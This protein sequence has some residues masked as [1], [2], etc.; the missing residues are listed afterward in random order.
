MR[1]PFRL[2]L[3]AALAVTAAAAQAD[4]LIIAKHHSDAIEFMGQKQPATD[5]NV[6]TWIGKGKVARL[7]PDL[8]VIV[9]ADI[10][11]MYL[12]RPAD[13]TYNEVD[14]PLDFKS[15]LPPEMAG[16]METMGKMMK[17][18]ATVTPTGETKTIA[19]YKSQ[20]YKVAISGP[21]G[22][23]IDQSIWATRELQID[24]DALKELMVNQRALMAP[25][26]GDWWKKLA[27]VEGFPVLSESVT[28]MG[29]KSFGTRE[30]I[31]STETKDAPAGTYDPPAG[32]KAEKFD[33]MAQGKAKKR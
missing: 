11:K 25:L 19:G 1:T 20:G 2:A 7:A 33:P 9:R 26:G 15:M 29:G 27:A 10:S 30:E 24:Y 8:S 28:T 13:K 3:V 6:Q 23:K 14:L 21:M 18:D 17:W 12:I 31:V 5:H 4:T 32:Y 16:M 22:M